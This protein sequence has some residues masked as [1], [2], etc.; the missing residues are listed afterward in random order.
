M[1]DAVT[2]EDEARRIFH[3]AGAL[4]ENDHFVYVSGDHG[5]GW[6]DKN[7]VYP[8][9]RNI[10]RLS[11]L[12]ADLVRDWPIEVV[13]GPATGGMVVAEWLAD[14]LDALAVFAE[15][16]PSAASGAAAPFVLRRGYDQLV[17]GKRVLAVDDI[18]NTGHSV[19]QTIAAVRAAG[20][21][22]VGAAAYIDRGNVDAAGLG[23]AHYRYLASVRIPAWPAASC[24]LCADGVP[25][26]TRYAHGAEFARSR[27]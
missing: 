12:L 24:T 4:L 11:E 14:R 2:P 16:D 20:G 18:V 9:P 21:E 26:N 17:R 23:V 3:D 15:H 27:G 25:V 8:R 13:C 10:V 22:V 6:I 5:S 7:V 1:A 19:R